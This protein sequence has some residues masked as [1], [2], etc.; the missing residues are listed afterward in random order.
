MVWMNALV[1]VVQSSNWEEGFGPPIPGF[2]SYYF[3]RRPAIITVYSK[4][5]CPG[6]ETL[7]TKLK[8]ANIVFEELNIDHNPDTLEWLLA[9]GHRS[10]PVL[11]RDGI[12]ISD[13]STILK[14][15]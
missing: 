10:V 2:K 14:G 11:Y 9:Q 1:V 5:N 4:N 12:H 15:A 6:C 13:V 7:K 8:R 3:W